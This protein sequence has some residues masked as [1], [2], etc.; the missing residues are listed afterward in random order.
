MNSLADLLLGVN[1]KL[2]AD[3]ILREV[4]LPYPSSISGGKVG[5][6]ISPLPHSLLAVDPARSEGARQASPNAACSGQQGSLYSPIRPCVFLSPSCLVEGVE[7]KPMAMSCSVEGFSRR[8]EQG[9]K[10]VRPSLRQ[11]GTLIPQGEFFK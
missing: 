10:D 1:E 7:L 9:C 5:R 8:I 6:L 4:R 11:I 2:E 3:S